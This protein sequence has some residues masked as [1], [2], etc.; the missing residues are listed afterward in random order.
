MAN[1]PDPL[2]NNPAIRQW[3]ERFYKLKAWT[4][5]DFP[6]PVDEEVDNRRSAALTELNKITIPAE[7]SSGARRSLAGGRKALKK[8]I[9]SADEAGAFDKI[10]SDISDLS[11]QIAAQ[12]AVAAARDKAQTALAAAEEKFASV[13]NSL[14]QGAFTYVEGLIKAAHKTMAAAVT[15][16]DFEAVEAAAKDASSKAEDANTY[17][18][19]FDNWTSAT[20]ALINPMTGVTKD[21]AEAA[22]GTQMKAAAV[23]SK[24]G[25][26]GAAKLALEAWKSNLSDEG[27][28]AEGLS[29]AAL[30]DDYMTNSHKRCELILA[31]AVPDAKDFRN[32]LKN[33]KKKGY[34]EQKFNEAKGLLQELID[35]SS[36]DRG[37]LARYMRGFDGSLRADEGFRNALAAADTK[38]KFKG[39]NDPAG[40]LADLKVWEKANR[41]LMR[42]SHSKQIVKALEAKYDTLKKVLAEPELSD[43]TTTWDAHKLLADADNFDKKTGAPQYHVKLNHLFQLEKVVDDRSEMARILTQFPEAAS[44][45]FHKPVADNITAQKY[46]DAVSAVPAALALLRAMPGYLTAKKAAED[47]LAVLPGDADVMKSTLDDAIKAAEFTARGGDPA[48]AA[49]DLQTVLDNA[50]YMDLV[51]AMADYR[52]KLAKV[53][54]EHARTKKYL[55]LPAAESKLDEALEA[56]KDRAGTDKE[57]G[58]AFLMLDTH[59]KLLKTVKPMA[60]ARFQVQGIIAALKRASVPSGELDPLEVKVAAAEDE[61]KKPDFDKAKTAFDK[62]RNELEKLSA[63]AAEAYE[64]L[65]GAG[66][67]AGHSLDRHGPDVSDEDLITRLKTGKPPNAHDD[68]ERSYTGASSKFHSPQDWLAGREIAAEAALAKGVDITETEMTFTGD[69][70]TDPDESADFTVEHGRPIDKAYIGHKKHVRSDDNGEPISDK[71]YESFEEVEGLTRAYVNFIWEPE[72]LPA[73]TTDNPDPATDYPEEKAQDNADY[74]AKYTTRHGAAPAKIPGRWVMMQQYP[75]ADGWDNET[76]TYTNGNPGNMIP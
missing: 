41:A 43:L 58:D 20:L 55:K 72:L 74:V 29:F 63:E 51:L 69:P 50:D 45:D 11:S 32:H 65:D 40:A 24:A 42:K 61:A 66:S 27:D 76:K 14:D 1:T 73:E 62:V 30:M 17:G 3:A 75:V 60:T 64:M 10:D 25:D 19:F 5:P 67:N 59:E 36:K 7:L 22:R 37:K 38:Q 46:P 21:T 71:T 56:A 57:Y 44:Y 26:F 49:G 31:S 6:D 39:N 68:D 33:A 28:L 2:A 8:E 34:K 48:K 16:K 52:A 35:Y 23:H 13:R 18:I 70:L 53:E 12:L 9:L 47:L 4:M 54:K 15:D